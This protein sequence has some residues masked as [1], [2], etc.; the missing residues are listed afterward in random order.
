VLVFSRKVAG[1]YAGHVGIYVAE[2]ASAF[3]VLGGNQ[4]DAVSVARVAKDRCVAVRRPAFA[5]AL[6]ASAKPYRV[7]TG[8]ALST[9]E[10]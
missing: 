7:A 2:D 8:G 1:G 9:N 5:T 4:G 10:A 3:H 6:P